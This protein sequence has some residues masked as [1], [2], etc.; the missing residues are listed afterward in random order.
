MMAKYK[1]G[2]TRN[3]TFTN[4][5]GCDSTATLTLRVLY[6]IY[7]PTNNL[8]TKDKTI[9]P[10]T[11][12]IEGNYSPGGGY[13][14]SPALPNGLN[15]NPLTG[16][17]SGTPT[18]VSPLQSYTI[19]LNQDG[20]NPTTF[21]LSVGVPSFSTTTIDNCGPLTWNGVVYDKAGTFKATLKN[22]YGYDS[23]ATLIL[24]IRNLSAS[25]TNLNL[26]LSQLPLIW[27]NTSIT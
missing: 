26:N 14:I 24:A 6:N 27:N 17:I 16:V 25:T 20:A 3:A 12:Q 9:T 18:Q 22:Q 15:L 10:I 8:L 4:A 7:Y 5:E 21:T 13:T 23:T 11:P 1:A 2:G 19:T